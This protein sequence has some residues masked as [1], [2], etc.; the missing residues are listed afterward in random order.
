MI[1]N[2]CPYCGK[3]NCVKDV[4]YLNEESYGNRVFDL[5]C[6][7]CDKMIHVVLTRTVH[8]KISKSQKDPQDSDF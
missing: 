2:V 7:L 5:P 6:K 3:E 1:W 8:T 4:V